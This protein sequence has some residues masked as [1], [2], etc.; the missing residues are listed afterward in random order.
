[1]ENEG[2]KP[3]EKRKTDDVRHTLHEGLEVKGKTVKNLHGMNRNKRTLDIHRRRMKG[4]IALCGLLFVPRVT[5][6]CGI[7]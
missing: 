1:M 4:N 7:L 5:A 2:E 3:E 6:T